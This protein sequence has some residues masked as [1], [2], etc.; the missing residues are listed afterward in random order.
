MIKNAI[1]YKEK[2]ETRGRKRALSPLHVNSLIHESTKDPFKPATELKRDLNITATVQ[3]VRKG[4]E[5]TMNIYR[6][7]LPSQGII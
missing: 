3:T 4:V 7:A 6:N 5:N 1:S 2:A